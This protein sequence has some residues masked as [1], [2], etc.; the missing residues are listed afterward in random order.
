M[1][2]F[3]VLQAAV[4]LGIA[5]LCCSVRV[6]AEYKAV[7]HRKVP[8][9]CIE[10]K[11]PGNCDKPGKTYVLT[12]DVTAEGSAIFLANDVTLDLNGY[13]ITY[14]SAK[15][16]HVPNYGFEEGLAG[17]DVSK[18]P[19]AKTE[20]TEK[21]KPFIGK[22]ICRLPAGSE[23]ASRYIALPVANRSYYAMCGV[24]DQKM[25]VTVSVE[26]EK[27]TPVQCESRFG[28][29]VRPS[30][31]QIGSPKLGGGFVFAH[32]HHL[33]AGKYRIRVKAETDCLIDEV[34]I[35]PALDV[36]VGIVER[37]YPWAYYKCIM[38]GDFAAFYDYTKPGTTSEPV[39]SIPRVSGAGKITVRNGVIRSGFEGIRSWAV[40]STAKD[41]MIVLENVKV[42]AGGINTNAVSVPRAII[43]DCR[44][45]IDT[46]FIID[47]HRLQDCAVSLREADGSEV[48]GSEFIGGQGC[49]CAS[50]KRDIL[51]H[52][53]L[54]V[55]RQTVTNHYSIAL[56]GCEGVKVYRNRIEPEIGS[57]IELYD[58]SNNEVYE[59]TFRITAANA[60]CE[61]TN[62]VYSTNAIRITDYNAKPGSP[63]AAAGNR[64]HHN[65]FH[66]IG[67]HY[68]NYA[69]Y[70]PFANAF[71]MSV[72]AG[73]NYIEDNEILVEHKDPNS[74][75]VACAFYIS[76]DNGGQY[77]RNK[78]TT[79]VPAFWIGNPYGPGANVKIV[80]NT[81]IKADNAPADFKPFRFGWW[82]YTATN[83]EFVANKFEGCEFGIQAT[84]AAHTYTRK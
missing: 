11:G 70:K 27:G 80:E 49:L 74:P 69:N 60:N 30:C 67:K 41:A 48:S 75:A 13:T 14:A 55:N 53:N 66:V 38:D 16:E 6:L 17:W 84:D 56:G 77:R 2:R 44:F 79:N 22:K 76:G 39:D 61:Y 9:G 82:K 29:N 36:G 62:D 20:D 46:P 81:V 8:E 71:F 65:K 78:I 57:G 64:I 68:A 31:P 42:Q 3:H 50:G 43:K 35:R 26:D 12:Q 21:V 28:S 40:Q 83:V 18:A 1:T 25:K 19:G 47:R 7:E 63:K 24:L 51:I 37:T 15:Y 52:D 72:G 10:V 54:F 73:A 58:A 34:D 32:V 45:E 4:T 5:L 59:N 33:P 23:I